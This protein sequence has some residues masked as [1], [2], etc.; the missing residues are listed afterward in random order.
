MGE[1]YYRQFDQDKCS[2]DS[3][4]GCKNFD[5]CKVFRAQYERK[6]REIQFERYE[7]ASDQ[8]VVKE[9]QDLTEQQIENILKPHIQEF[10]SERTHKMAVGKMRVFLRKQ[11]IILSSWK[12]RQIKENLEAAFPEL[13]PED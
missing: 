12:T 1:L 3:C 6:K 2:K 11:K 4:L 5:N 13:F 10:I 9:T 7:Q 8:A